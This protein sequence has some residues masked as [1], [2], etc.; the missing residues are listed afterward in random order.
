MGKPPM[1]EEEFLQKKAA[2]QS[3]GSVEARSYSSGRPFRNFEK[4]GMERGPA[5]RLATAAVRSAAERLRFP[6]VPAPVAD[7]NMEM[8]VPA[9]VD[10]ATGK[11]YFNPRYQGTQAEWTSIM[12]EE[13]LHMA[14]LVGANRSLS[15]QIASL[16]PDG[17]LFQEAS[18]VV[19]EGSGPLVEF[20]SYPLGDKFSGLSNAR[21]AAELFAR[22]GV[23][24]QGDSAAMQRYLPKAHE[25]FHGLFQQ[26][27]LGPNESVLRD[28]RATRSEGGRQGVGGKRNLPGTDG[29]NRQSDRRQNASDGLESFSRAIAD[30][31]NVSAA[32]GK[33]TGPF[34][35]RVT[36]SAKDF[37]K[38]V[39]KAATTT[40]MDAPSEIGSTLHIFLNNHQVADSYKKLISAKR[41][42]EAVDA[43][44]A[45]A[46]KNEQII[47]AL[48]ERMRAL[49]PDP[50]G[51]LSELMVQSTLSGVHVDK[52]VDDKANAHLNKD[53]GDHNIH[54]R[55]AEKY[56]ALSPEAQAV[57][58]EMRDHFANMWA[59]RIQG[60]KDFAERIGVSGKEM[61][62]LDSELAQLSR[63]VKGPYFPL[64]R[65]GKYVV[66]WKSQALLDA[67]KNEDE[68]AIDELKNSSADYWVRFTDSKTEAKMLST[69]RPEKMGDGA[70][71]QFKLRT[72]ASREV[73]GAGAEFMSKLE[74]ALNQ[75][76]KDKDTKEVALGALKQVFMETL[77]DLSVM[78]RTMMR[79]GV[80]GVKSEDMV[81]AI[82]KAGIADSHYLARLTHADS[83]TSALQDLRLEDA[84]PRPGEEI[85][86]TTPGTPKGG[87][88]AIYNLISKSYRGDMMRPAN[89]GFAAAAN[90]LVE[91][92][93]LHS[94]AMDTGNLIAN[95][96][97]PTLTV[98]PM[99][100][101]RHGFVRAQREMWRGLG[102]ALKVAKKVSYDLN[103]DR[104]TNENG[105]RDALQKLRDMGVVELSMSRDMASIGR[106]ESMGYDKFRKYMAVPAHYIETVTRISSVLAA[107]RL[108]LAQARRD[109]QGISEDARRMKAVQYAA[110]IS[111]EAL[112]DFTPGGSPI[113]MKGNN[114]ALAK[115]AMQYKRFAIAM[116]YLY[117]KTGWDAFNASNLKDRA[118]ARKT[119]A[120]MMGAQF[121]IAGGLSGL[122]VALLA[123]MAASLWPT[124]D[125]DES[126]EEKLNRLADTLAGGNPTL[127]MAL[128]K[129]PL[130][131]LTGADFSRKMGLSDLII[132]NTSQLFEELKPHEKL[133]TQVANALM[134][135]LGFVDRMHDGGEM[136]SNGDLIGGVFKLL[137]KTPATDIYAA[138]QAEE[139]GMTSKDK[140]SK[141]SPLE[142]QPSDLVFKAMGIPPLLETLKWEASDVYNSRENP[143]T[144]ERERILDAWVIA[145]K[146]ND[147]EG[148]ADAQSKIDE[149]NQSLPAGF[150]KY[151]IKPQ[152]KF[153]R[154]QSS[155]KGEKKLTET[156]IKET[157]RNKPWL[158]KLDM[159]KPLR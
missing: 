153:S 93:Y 146:K 56:Q 119:F 144:D 17:E 123:K 19:M 118:E 32:G 21:K 44:Q 3:S 137:P 73:A 30:H 52:P 136:I 25:V 63:K 53:S 156:G 115:M 68:K 27:Q 46:Q 107:Y 7:P 12:L 147:A 50:L 57:Y 11:L 135:S 111:R 120:A 145:A 105:E 78:K 8:D 88:G 114:Q 75:R 130:A 72:E 37:S 16:Q 151:K 102:D 112:V 66:V 55:L 139:N 51:K 22:L 61:T 79:R 28:V 92:S 138:I 86:L 45:E 108:E 152:D 64:M 35:S 29:G 23:L 38:S 15:S 143:K 129:G 97:Q 148:K 154:T 41:Y 81:R 70:Y 95:M 131:A 49:D 103:I 18:A 149:Y 117:S 106:G 128:R 110:R 76:I 1:S 87:M 94:L 24:Y 54:A 58:S 84:D 40:A 62:K 85:D 36:Q 48:T 121:A 26:S 100:G 157:K 158:D 67:E 10:T 126:A 2:G 91:L 20:L 150:E 59:T 155:R 134:P 89:E 42:A 13:L 33:V 83:I 125:D 60:V 34:E 69:N 132:L 6:K 74:T 43:M 122:P 133:S 142:Y 104:L 71:G 96:M 5:M 113:M 31:F 101:G 80:A 82:A 141:V 65:E 99:L 9:R 127:S 47:G 109:E 159:Y 124:E 4:Y 90:R 116:L 39:L 77:P 140:A 14:D 98:L